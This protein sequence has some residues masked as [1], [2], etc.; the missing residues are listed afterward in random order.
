[1]AVAL[2]AAALL[3][4]GSVVPLPAFARNGDTTVRESG[5][6]KARESKQRATARTKGGRPAATAAGRGGNG[7]GGTGGRGGS[8]SVAKLERGTTFIAGSSGSGGPGGTG[9]GGLGGNPTLNRT[10][11]RDVVGGHGGTG[12]GGRGGKGGDISI[13]QVSG[14]RINTGDAGTGGVGGLALGGLGGGRGTK[15]AATRAGLDGLSFGGRGGKGGNISISRVSGGRVAVG[16]PGPGG[17][18]AS[19]PATRASAGRISIGHLTISRV[20]GGTIR[21]RGLDIDLVDLRKGVRA[22]DRKATAESERPTEKVRQEDAKVAADR[23]ALVAVQRVKLTEPRSGSTKNTSQV[24]AAATDAAYPPD[25]ALGQAI[26]GQVLYGPDGTRIGRI[27][28]IV[29]GHGRTFTA[30]VSTA[31]FLGARGRDVAVPL[32]R[33]SISEGG[34]LLATALRKS[35]VSFKTTH[36]MIILY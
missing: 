19:G 5:G 23:S 31:G 33:V 10:F 35:A 29:L 18:G 34:W 22:G 14:G 30:L 36:P 20:T 13:S 7:Q 11:A 24:I 6:S 26:V 28:N 15:V 12:F 8:I 32:D 16:L 17:A 25:T 2:S 3:V 21:L 1:M 4:V 27:K 9:Q